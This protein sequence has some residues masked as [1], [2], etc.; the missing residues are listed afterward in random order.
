MFFF[1]FFVFFL[2]FWR[3]GILLCCPGWF[4]TPGLKWS[5]SSASHIAG[6]TGV[7][8]LIQVR[9]IR[10]EVGWA[11]WLTPVTAACWE[12]KAGGPLEVRSLRPAWPT[13]W[14]RVPTK[15]TKISWAWW[16]VP[17]V[18]ATWEAEAGEP[19][20]PRRWR[21]Q[22]AKTTPLHSSL[23]TVRDFVSKKKKKKKRKEKKNSCLLNR[24]NS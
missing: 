9:I 14:N 4:R 21:S 1:L 10:K 7:S 8:H 12:A 19:V 16:C 20:E 11:R 22:W 3:D 5:P 15:N 17:I 24:I 18:Q 2:F 13:W 23:V 6:L